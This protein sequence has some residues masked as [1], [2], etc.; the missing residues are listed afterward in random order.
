[1]DA[2]AAAPVI[3]GDPAL[4]AILA[5]QSADAT[6]LASA[7]PAPAASPA[8]DPY[9]EQWLKRV[10]PS[11]PGP[12]MAEGVASSQIPELGGSSPN[13]LAAAYGNPPPTVA[14]P[15][16][17]AGAPPPPPAGDPKPAGL[18]TPALSL[19][20]QGAAAYRPPNMSGFAGQ[21]RNAQGVEEKGIHERAAAEA[22][23]AKE[24]AAAL[25]AQVKVQQEY[26]AQSRSAFDGLTKEHDSIARDV[27]NTHI[28]PQRLWANK[29]SSQKATAVIGMI[30]GGIGSGLTGQPN[31]AL[32]VIQ[33]QIE[34]DIDAQKSELGKKENLLSDNLRKFGNLDAAVKMTQL[35][36]TAGLEGQLK[37]AAARSGSADAIGKADALIG[38]SRKAMVPQYADLAMRQASMAMMSGASAAP[39]GYLPSRAPPPMPTE[40]SLKGI[41]EQRKALSEQTVLGPGGKPYIAFDAATAQKTRPLGAALE[42]VRGTLAQVKALRDSAGP[43]GIIP[44]TQ[45]ANLYAK[46]RAALPEQWAMAQG[47]TQPSEVSNE[48]LEKVMPSAWDAFARGDFTFDPI[49][50]LLDEREEA[51][52]LSAGLHPSNFAARHAFVPAKGK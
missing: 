6:P 12:T 46:L 48:N 51:V 16:A 42:Q 43:G 13:D 23:A 26:T 2:T 29:S 21:L 37:L 28:D 39:Q 31:A 11:P 1:M 20:G 9:M 4:D 7:A 25:D 44:G 19:D 3:T 5:H 14:A 34:Q 52:H 8:A 40:F 33:H 24:S 15:A 30:L 27:A 18:G 35:Q 41:A 32:A 22:Q 10:Q 47:L 38:Q 49:N 45:A 17:P 36:M 50:K